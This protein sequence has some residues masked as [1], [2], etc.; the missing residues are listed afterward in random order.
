VS[1]AIHPDLRGRVALVTGA[2]R[3]IGKALAI[4]LAE[5]G[6]DVAILAKSVQSSERLPGSIHET[7]DA[8]RA[9]GRKALPIAADVRDAEAL[10]IAIEQTAAELGRLDI[11][12]NNAG[13][14]WTES[15]L[16]TPPKRFDLV[17]G[18]NVRAAYIA[19]HY[20]LP[21]MVRQGWGHILNMCP[22]LST[23]PKPGKVA[24]MISK[25][26]MAQL[27]IGLAAEHVNDNIAANTLWP[28]TIIESQASINWKMADRS[29]WRTPEI[30]CDAACAI[31]GQEPRTCTGRQ[32][33][34]EEALSELASFR[35]F[36][37]Y[38]CEGHPPETPIYIDQ[39]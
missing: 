18:V 30:L 19:C 3:G 13:A 9:L 5:E 2:S 37:R 4:R 22:R 28:R 36:D 35:Q 27:A 17:M 33:V 10:R 11:L 25:L 12:V 29:Q 39:W 26:G 7:A 24:Y 34:D 23:A 6:A 1:E 38:W 20:A 21:Y 31:F 8:I 15:I 14:I 16:K 32:W